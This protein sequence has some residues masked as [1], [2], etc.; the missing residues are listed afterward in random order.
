MLE[1]IASLERGVVLLTGDAKR[2]ARIFLNLWL[3]KGKVFLVE[4][5]PFEVDYPEKVFIGSI[6][7]GFEFDGYV[8]YSLLSRPKPER[9]KYYSF[10]A[11]H[12]DKLILIYEP[13]YFRDSI[14]RYAVKDF[15]DY[16]VAYKRE[17]MGMDMVDVYKLED[18]RVVK[19]K[20][21]VRRF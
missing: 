7:E 19:R 1:E 14:L 15:V 12:R 11:E 6:E 3:S 5:L 10:I 17:T 16:L 13:K 18:G 4:Y 8:V 9:A 20:T 2:L 21:Y